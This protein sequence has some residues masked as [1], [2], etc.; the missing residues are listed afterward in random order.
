MSKNIYNI[1]RNQHVTEKSLKNNINNKYVFKVSM[2]AEKSEL[3]NSIEKIF[4]VKVSAINTII[5]KKII[6]KRT[7]TTSV[8]LTKKWKKAIISLN[9]GFSINFNDFK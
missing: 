7:K 3:K 9:K 6:T 8:K 5:I 2:D 1:I 4:N